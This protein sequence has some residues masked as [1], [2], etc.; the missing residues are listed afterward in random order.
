MLTGH[1]SATFSSPILFKIMYFNQ[2]SSKTN[3]RP[4]IT[5]KSDY[6]LP[7]DVGSNHYLMIFCRT[8]ATRTLDHYMT[9]IK[10]TNFIK[11]IILYGLSLVKESSLILSQ[12]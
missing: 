11:D 8:G 5:W 10:V 12:M 7:R 9:H 6:M 3:F 1:I 4:T 2:L